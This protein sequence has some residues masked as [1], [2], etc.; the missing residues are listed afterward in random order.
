MPILIEQSNFTDFLGNTT[1]Y[2]KSDSGDKI[3]AEFSI[4]SIIR[5]S[6]IGNPLTLDPTVNQIVSPT[7]WIEEGFRVNQWVLIQIHSSG[8][9][10]LP[11]P[12]GQFWSLVNYVDD[13]MIDI[14][15]IPA[16]YNIQNNE[17]VSIRAVTDHFRH[18][19]VM[20]WK[21]KLTTLKTVYRMERLL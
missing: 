3:I 21:C 15:G 2:Y 5:I 1:S 17:S 14:N 10:I 12:N 18:Y 4:R 7:S 11:G 16:W 9:A 19:A 20:I 6:S 13:V 8:G